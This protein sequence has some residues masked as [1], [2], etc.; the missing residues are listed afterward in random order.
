[1]PLE[2]GKSKKAFSHNVKTEM[3]AGKPQKQAVAIAYSEAGE[4][5]AEAEVEAAIRAGQEESE[6]EE[7][8]AEAGKRESTHQKRALEKLQRLQERRSEA[9]DEFK[10]SD[11]PRSDDGKFGSGGGSGKSSS[12]GEKSAARTIAQ[13]VAK[14]SPETRKAVQRAAEK[15][16]AETDS[17]KELRRLKTIIG[18]CERA[19]RSK[20][21]SF[22]AEEIARAVCAED[23]KRRALY[24][25]VVPIVG[26]FDHDEMSAREIAAHALEK[27]QLPKAKDPVMALE[28][29]LAGSQPRAMA[30]DADDAPFLT[31]YLT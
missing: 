18:A 3:K 13:K 27:L 17:K 6:A 9:A 11:H 19:S 22:D 21:S 7:E 25:Q 16:I 12:S 4:D 24:R 10:E 23:A 26:A 28:F 2:K 31:E 30:H 5:S 14:M 1:M 8:A 29:Y 15:K 20:D